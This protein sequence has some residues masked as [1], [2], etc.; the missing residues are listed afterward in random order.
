LARTSISEASRSQR[1]IALTTASSLAL[2][3]FAAQPAFAQT[4][5]DPEQ[6]AT[7]PEQEDVIVVKGFRKSL[8]D[9]QNIKR[10]SDT[11][12]DSITAEDIG[13]LPDR[14]VA[15]ALQRVPGVNISRF[16]N[17]D[18]P[19]RFSVEGSGVI[20]RG[21]TFIRSELNGRDI[22][23]ANGGREL[24]F[25]DISPEL[26]GGVNV[27][28]NTTADMI[29]GGIS[30]NVNLITRKPLNKRGLHVAGTVE[31]NYGDMAKKWS[32]G[33]SVLASDTFETGIGTFG[34][35]VAYAKSELVTKT[36]ASQIT[37]PCYRAKTL[38]SGCIRVRPV[39]S[40]GFGGTQQFNASNF[41]P[42]NA[43]FVPKG[44]GVRTTDLT[45]NRDALSA[46]GQWES[47]DGRAQLTVE[48]LR[49]NTKGTLN[50][51][52]ILAL[53]NDDG[54]FPTIAPG[55]TP[56]FIGN[57]FATGT[58]TQVQPFTGGRGIPTELLRFQRADTARTEDISAQL[59]L[60]P[61]DRLRF[62]F[63]VQHIKSDRTEDGFIS[64]MQT[65]TDVR[66]DNSGSTPQVEFL[67]PGGTTS[68]TSYFNDPSKTFYWFLL[69]NQVKNDGALTTMRA[70]AEYDVSDEGRQ[71][72][73]RRFSSL[74]LWRRLCQRFP[75]FGKSAQ[76]IWR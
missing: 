64:A 24:S 12:V 72:E 30:G 40:G 29:E 51:Y 68:P 42:A 67:Q 21:L 1:F 75:G 56:T 15:E 8:E 31:G 41:P 43:V 13:A 16:A 71:L 9:A 10:N 53:V 76:S 28:K 26:L 22:F 38:D 19:D 20:I 58:L 48:Y 73:L 17:R 47:N 55:T 63:E 60:Q 54:L 70:D 69:D 61:S 37:D 52:A 59:K 6:A 2:C 45:R 18:D 46:V 50:E 74:W 32:P 44:A 35:Q 14:S 36:D 34:L 49:A 4:A 23:S 5:E 62:N 7:S 66:I 57:Q 11:V 27:Y 33:F 3:A 25:N 39:G 65:Y